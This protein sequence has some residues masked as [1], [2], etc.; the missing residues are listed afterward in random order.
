VLE[1]QNLANN[2]TSRRSLTLDGRRASIGLLYIPDATEVLPYCT[3]GGTLS[4]CITEPSQ[5]SAINLHEAW[6]RYRELKLLY[7]VDGVEGLTAAMIANHQ[8]KTEQGELV[9]V[10]ESY[11]GG[12]NPA[13]V[14]G[15]LKLSQAL[16]DVQGYTLRLPEC[17]NLENDSQIADI[18]MQSKSPQGN[19]AR[20]RKTDGSKY[21]HTHNGLY[22]CPTPDG[23]IF[24][25][26]RQ[27]MARHGLLRG[28]SNRFIK[29][30]IRVKCEGYMPMG[31][32]LQY[33]SHRGG[34]QEM[35]DFVKDRD[36]YIC[37][38]SEL[39]HRIVALCNEARGECP[40]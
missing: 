13:E 6:Q 9:T 20:W 40:W 3:P 15:H 32:A 34:P 11:R 38:Y 33:Y 7:G 26:T 18:L 16:K 19:A 17:E 10:A 8:S 37:T 28:Q 22:S 12:S 23:R 31:N 30:G 35:A 39:K 29:L 5:S 25:G 4:L 14:A 2:Y 21:S 36:R 27:F 24:V 1:F